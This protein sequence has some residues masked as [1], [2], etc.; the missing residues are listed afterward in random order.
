MSLT[1]KLAFPELVTVTDFVAL[2]FPTNTPRKLRLAGDSVIAGAV[3]VP[4]KATLCGLPAALSVTL[5]VDVRLPVLVGLNTALIVQLALAASVDPQVFVCVKSRRLPPVT[6]M[7]FNESVDVPVLVSVTTCAV[8]LV[9]TVW[10]PKVNEVGE[11]RTVGCANNKVENANTADTAAHCQ[12]AS[13]YVKRISRRTSRFSAVLG[14]ITYCALP[15]RKK[16]SK[17][18]PAVGLRLCNFLHASCGVFLLR[19]SL[20]FST[21]FAD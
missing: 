4:L 19:I 14:G 9:P 16:S 8:L 3:P 13:L 10:L 11:S 17:N 15:G 20:N 6:L 7:P 2:L 12:A 1:V 21:D 18:Q 5:T